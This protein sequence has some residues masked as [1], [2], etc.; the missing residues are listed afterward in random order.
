[1]GF[2]QF[3]ESDY[4]VKMSDA[5]HF[6]VNYIILCWTL[7]DYKQ[8]NSLDNFLSWIL[9]VFFQEVK[10]ESK[11]TCAS[12]KDIEI[13]NNPKMN[14]TKTSRFPETNRPH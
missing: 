12:V 14:E 11:R 1:M 7:K 8:V 10:K 13:I 5:K 9:K 2:L 3:V 4:A 6:Q